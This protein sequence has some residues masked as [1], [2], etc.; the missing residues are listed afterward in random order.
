[1]VAANRELRTPFWNSD[2]VGLFRAG[3]LA[4]SGHVKTAPATAPHRLKNSRPSKNR[5]IPGSC[6]EDLDRLT[7]SVSPALVV[8]DGSP[9][10][11]VGGKLSNQPGAAT[12]F[13]D[14]WQEFRK[15]F[16]C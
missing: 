8:T 16:L 15:D 3:S 7:L 5:R 13:A 12:S 2:S 14:P 10:N 11:P 9:R 4:L 1:V 6:S